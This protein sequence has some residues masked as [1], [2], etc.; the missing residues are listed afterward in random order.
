MRRGSPQP[1]RRGFT[2]ASKL[3]AATLGVGALVF[4]LMNGCHAVRHAPMTTRFPLAEPNTVTYI[5][6]ATVL[7]RLNGVTALTDPLYS[8]YVG[9]YRRYVAPGV[10]L[11][12]L[13]AL[14]LILLSHGHWDH[15]D[16]ATL[17]RLDKGAVLIVPDG[18]QEDVRGLGFR[19]VRGLTQGET[20]TV[21]GAAVTAVP[22]QHW[23]TACGYLIRKG[24]AV[25]FAGDTGLFAGMR[26]IGEQGTI[27]LA[28]LPI[29]A[30]RP[31]LSFVPGAS[32]AMRRVHMA[33]EDVPPVAE[34]LDAGLVVPVHWGTFKLTGEPI[35]EPLERLQR[36]IRG[37]DL[38]GRVRIVVHGETTAF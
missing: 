37:Q 22:V 7:L 1:G 21:R 12:D 38:A 28:L 16:T 26:A 15:L 29:G 4:V 9:I 35:D 30:Y 3:S 13:P 20:T 27:D 25:Y 34:M 18:L 2:T 5:G 23:G 10:P 31:H 24:K 32:R 33:P 19:E 6:H 11:Q 36:V 8:E 17:Q 14:D